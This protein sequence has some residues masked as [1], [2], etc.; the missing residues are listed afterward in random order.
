[1]VE[2]EAVDIE[3]MLIERIPDKLTILHFTASLGDETKVNELMS[4]LDECLTDDDL[5]DLIFDCDHNFNTCV[6]TAAKV[7][8]KSVLKILFDKIRSLEIS[9][10]KSLYKENFLVEN[11]FHRAFCS[12]NPETFPTIIDFLRAVR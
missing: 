7:Y 8:T 9:D 6:H 11:I 5:K 4:L 2:V 1:M 10:R 3:A 12:K